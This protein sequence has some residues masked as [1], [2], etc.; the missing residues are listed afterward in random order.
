MRYWLPVKLTL[1]PV[2]TLRTIWTVSR[3]RASGWAN[4][5]PCSPSRTWGPETPRPS[6]NRPP[7]RW[8]SVIAV[9]AITTGER[10][11]TW[12][13]ADPSSIVSV[14]AAR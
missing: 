4:G 2:N 14:R 8:A 9:C 10:V 3:I 13:T 6:R 11:P 7:D 1:S 12:M 5:T